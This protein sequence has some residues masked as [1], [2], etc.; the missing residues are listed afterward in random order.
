ML[1][2][3]AISEPLKPAPSAGFIE[4]VRANKGRLVMAV[5]T[6]HEVL[7]GLLRM[8]KGKRKDTVK[9]WLFDVIAVTLPML[10][11][12]GEAAEWHAGERVRLAAKGRMPSFADGQIAAIAKVRGFTVVTANMKDFELFEEV[13]V[14]DWWE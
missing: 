13:S 14:E 7:Y 2:T 4:K 10:P 9:S 8:P 6:W 11:Y 12:D 3:N 5:T 1:D